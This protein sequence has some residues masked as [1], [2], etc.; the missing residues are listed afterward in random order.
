VGLIKIQPGDD[1]SEDGFACDAHLTAPGLAGPQQALEIGT[2]NQPIPATCTALIQLRYFEGM[3]KESCPAIVCC[4]GRMDIHGAPM[5][6]TWVKLAA[7]A[8]LTQVRLMG[9]P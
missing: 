2:P 3:D 8:S 9:A 4:G 6:R 5:S 1:A 7:P